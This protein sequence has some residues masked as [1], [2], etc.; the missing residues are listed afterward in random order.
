[1]KICT[2]CKQRTALTDFPK[3]KNTISGLGT[4][5]KACH[6]NYYIPGS[7][8]KYQA[9]KRKANPIKAMLIA[10]KHRAKLAGIPF[11]LV[12]DDIQMPLY[13]PILGVKLIYGA[14]GKLNW[15]NNTASLDRINNNKGY[16]KGNVHIVSS[17]FNTLKS[18]LSVDEII[19]MAE[20]FS[21][22][23]EE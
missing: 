6:R 4:H 12:E 22:L 18:N 10:A 1:M 21:W 19:R 11:N 16:V 14:A 20:Y 17:K 9:D 13:C 7:R 5:C 3:N 23:V 8:V 2:K 15:A